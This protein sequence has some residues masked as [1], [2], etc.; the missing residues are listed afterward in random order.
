[1]IDKIVLYG[2]YAITSVLVFGAI[3][4]VH[5][6]GHFTVAKL[7]GVHVYEFSIGFGP[8]L[9]GFRKRE[10]AYNLRVIPLGG[11]V[12]MAGMDSEEDQREAARS[13]E[14]EP[15]SAEGSHHPEEKSKVVPIVEP[16]KSFSHKSVPQRM[17]II[18]C[19]PLM[20]FILA[21]VLFVVTIWMS[22][23]PDKN[24]VG[25][26]M[27]GKP[28][29]V[30][31]IRVGDT[32]N[33][34]NDKPVKAWEEIIGIIHNSPNKQIKLE[35]GRGQ[36]TREFKVV[37]EKDRE[38]NWGLIGV[39][40]KIRKP[41]VF[42]SM[43]LGVAKSYAMLSLTADFIGKMMAKQIPVQLSGPVRITYELGKAAQVGL[44]NVINI[45]GILSLQI[46]LFNLLPIPALDGSR[47]MFLGVEGIRGMP[48]DPSKENFIHLV[49]LALL[50]LLMV[51]ITYQDIAQMIS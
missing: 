46:G 40:P 39:I 51:V 2:L 8:R 48:I 20:N 43:K 26:V 15:E 28:A 14:N 30:I 16:A 45:A 10:T 6:L 36:E 9:A 34:I 24:I 21:I 31:G 13:A 37:P 12:R 1:M 50:L 19:G 35:I 47:L 7:A 32:I 18:A 5:E 29:D 27:K 25:Q 38:T 3:V 42:E 49:G 23:L 44:I 41:G 22:G 33:R 17:A 11:Y 4:L